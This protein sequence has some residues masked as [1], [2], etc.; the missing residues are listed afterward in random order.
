MAVSISTITK[1]AGWAKTDVIYALEEAFTITQFH[2]DTRTGIVTFIDSYSG[3]GSISG[4]SDTYEDVFPVTTTG[5]GT[6]ASFRVQ[7]SSG[8]VNTIYVNRPGYGYTDGEYITLSSEDIGG[9]SNGAVAI[10]ITVK[11]AG[12]ET[13]TGYGSST[14]FYVKDDNPAGTYPWAVLRHE[15]QPNKKFGNTFRAFQTINDYTLSFGVGSDFHPWGTTNI[16]NKYS[17]YKNRWAGT[18]QLDSS[19]YTNNTDLVTNNYASYYDSS[20]ISDGYVSTASGATN[21]T[22]R[23]DG[24]GSGQRIRYATTN[25]PTAHDL[26]LKVYRSSI[27]PKFAVFSFSQPSVTA[28]SITDNTFLTFILHNFDSNLWDLDDVF[29]GGLTLI[30]PETCSASNGGTPGRLQFATFLTGNSH[31]GNQYRY[32]VTRSSWRTA[33]AGYATY[34]TKT[35][36]FDVYES[37]SSLYGNEQNTQNSGGYGSM[38]QPIGNSKIYTRRTDAKSSN[39]FSTYINSNNNYNAVIKGIPLNSNLI[40]CPYYLPDDFVLIDFKYTASATNIQQGDTITISG[41]EV[42]EV[43]TGSYNQFTNTSGLL[44]CARTV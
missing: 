34:D 36:A 10:G 43:I 32:S 21:Q 23:Y 18:A 8:P 35:I 17:G 20:Y 24:T 19:T 12:N 40:P 2:G 26:R 11:V 16:I 6:G 39:G 13:P 41:S 22:G 3:G 28:S 4:S 15:I 9:S 27:D 38:D 31:W 44:F 30:E 1:S 7:R 5:I 14:T 29:L 25:S 33:E 37:T 42:Y